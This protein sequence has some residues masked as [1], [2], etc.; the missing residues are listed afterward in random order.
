M[1]VM[2]QNC[3][4]GR[5]TATATVMTADLFLFFFPLVPFPPSSQRFKSRDVNSLVEGLKLFYRVS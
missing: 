3:F 5:G 2:R 4:Q 1:S